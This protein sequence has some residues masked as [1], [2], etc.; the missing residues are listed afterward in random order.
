LL[1]AFFLHEAMPRSNMRGSTSMRPLL[2]LALLVILVGA[3]WWAL[4][5]PSDSIDDP[6]QVSDVQDADPNPAKTEAVAD[7]PGDG[8]VKETAATTQER[9]RDEVAVGHRVQVLGVEG[10]AAP[11][12]PV[13]YY[14][15]AEDPNRFDEQAARLASGEF[16]GLQV[17]SNAPVTGPRGA[18]ILPTREHCFAWAMIEGAAGFVLIPAMPKEESAEPHILQLQPAPM[19]ELI[20]LDSSG[21]AVEGGLDFNALVGSARMI[22]LQPKSMREG[23]YGSGWAHTPNQ[24]CTLADGRRMFSLI[25][26]KGARDGIGPNPGKLRYRLKFDHNGVQFPPRE[27]EDDVVGPIIYQLPDSG[28]LTLQL[29]G[30]PEGAVPGISALGSNAGLERGTEVEGSEGRSWLFSD[31]SVGMSWQV[32]FWCLSGEGRARRLVGTSL[33]LREVPGPSSAGE[34]AEVR[35]EFAWP[36]GFHGRLM[37]PDEAGVSWDQFVSDGS[38]GLLDAEL[39]FHSGNQRRDWARVGIFPDGRFFIPLDTERRSHQNTAA[40]SGFELSFS[41]DQPR[42][43]PAG[44]VPARLWAFV[45][46]SLPTAQAGVDVGEVKLLHREPLFKVLVSNSSGKPVP[47]AAVSFSFAS[48]WDRPEMDRERFRSAGRGTASDAHGE[49]WLI[50][51]DWQSFSPSFRDGEVDV[52]PSSVVHTVRVNIEH[53]EFLPVQV[54]FTGGERTARVTLAPAATVAGSVLAFRGGTA[55]LADLLPVG[56]PLGEGV[57]HTFIH[58]ARRG[59]ETIEFVFDGVPLGSWDVVFKHSSFR[60]NELLRVSGVEV[61][62]SG[63][64]RDPRLQ[65]VDL[66]NA[67]GEVRLRIFRASGVR[68]TPGE[69]SESGFRLRKYSAGGG[70]YSTGIA[71]WDGDEIVALMPADAEYKLGIEADGWAVKELNAL[72]PGTHDVY[73]TELQESRVHITNFSQLPEGVELE[74]VVM[75]DRSAGIV[76]LIQGKIEQAEVPVYWQA[77]GVHSATWHLRKNSVGWSD[78]VKT[79]ITLT[80]EQLRSGSVLELAI[81]E[82]LLASIPD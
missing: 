27:F 20:V 47:S 81:P 54:D 16:P 68:L 66:G 39:R 29:D 77:T 5:P 72:R 55:I 2:F 38:R 63:T 74:L 58:G 75:P 42:D 73:L 9:E 36:P 65:G 11:G 12:V 3:V 51:R 41:S 60:E 45:D 79:E 1:P 13:T 46:A 71:D 61:S 19:V 67:L 50:A 69:I 44:W 21:T 26:P 18:L 49:A 34:Q 62:G 30:Y 78:R 4:T 14:V 15:D 82:S 57:R 53:P 31:V 24:V 28:T 22:D 56:A 8:P 48:D 7:L 35:L 52:V 23:D 6:T 17:S 59:E 64:V 70:G 25:P 32:G 33:P 40:I 76:Y 37:F 43:E 10:R 80:D